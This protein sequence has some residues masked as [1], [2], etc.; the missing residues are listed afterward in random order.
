MDVVHGPSMLLPEG[1]AGDVLRG[2]ER[3]EG[4]DGEAEEEDKVEGVDVFDELQEARVHEGRARVRHVK[5]LPVVVSEEDRRRQGHEVHGRLDDPGDGHLRRH[6]RSGRLGRHGVVAAVRARRLLLFFLLV[7]VYVGAGEPRA[8]D[9]GPVA[10]KEGLPLGDVEALLGLDVD[11]GVAVE[12][13]GVR[14]SR[15]QARELPPCAKERGVSQQDPPVQVDR[16]GHGVGRGLDEARPDF[17]QEQRVRIALGGDER[18]EGRHRQHDRLHVL[19][20]GREVVGPRALQEGRLEVRRR[21]GLGL[22]V[23]PPKVLGQPRPESRAP[24]QRR[25]QRLGALMLPDGHRQGGQP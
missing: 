19:R 4:I 8:V 18:L 25:R 21:P 22:S 6:V 12:I 15:R 14:L 17:V 23:E 1:A 10:R 5:L 7:I 2:V 16:L 3:R 9:V 24:A 20:L 13:T 11:D